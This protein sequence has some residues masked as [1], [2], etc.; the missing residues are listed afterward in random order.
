MLI[1]KKVIV[2]TRSYDTNDHEMF[3]RKMFSD[4]TIQ[5]DGHSIPVHKNILYYRNK[6]F[7]ALL[8]HTCLE[9]SENILKIDDFSFEVI[10]ELL[11]FIYCGEVKNLE[12]DV[13]ELLPAA[14]KVS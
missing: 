7:A 1:P 3:E 6:F 4:F 10:N 13:M 8:S 11:R 12:E 5:V 9:T 2:Q 14:D